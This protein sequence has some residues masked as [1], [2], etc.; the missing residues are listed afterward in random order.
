MYLKRN[1]IIPGIY[2]PLLPS[3]GMFDILLLL[4]LQQMD[5]HPIG[6][7]P[8]NSHH[9]KMH[10]TIAENESKGSIYDL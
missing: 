6:K 5:P 7:Q 10:H 8:A 2:F 4:C 9:Q 3:K 1:V